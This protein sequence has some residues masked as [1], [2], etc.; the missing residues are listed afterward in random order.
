MMQI[1]TPDMFD[2]IRAIITSLFDVPVAVG[3]TDPGQD[4][5]ALMGGEGAHLSQAL[6]GRKREFAAGRSAARLAMSALGHAP[7]A[8]PAAVDRAPIWPEGLRGSI[9]HTASLCAAVVTDAP[10]WLGL[11]IEGKEDLNAGLLTTI[12]SQDEIDRIT[13]PDHLRLAKLIFSAK[14][15]AYKAQYPM[16]GM[17]FGFDHLDV[18]VDEQRHEFIARLVKPAGPFAVGDTLP[19]RFDAVAGH[20]VTAV[21]ARHDSQKGA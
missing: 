16:T 10:V 8:I 9:S 18:T 2:Q 20:I 7:C 6:A 19:G 3:V 21:I 17:L 11:D 15:A 4:Q 12:C 13:G 14:E 1:N 5:P